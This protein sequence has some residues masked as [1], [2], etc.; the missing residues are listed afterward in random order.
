[1][2][3]PV[4]LPASSEALAPQLVSMRTLAAEGSASFDWHS[5]PFEEFTLVTDDDCLI[6]YPPGWRDT[7]PNT[8]LYYHTGEKHGAWSSPQQRP[9]FWVVHFRA[10]PGVH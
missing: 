2:S 10:G 5:H 8:L 1:M 9:H 4:S 3:M 7:A 6:G